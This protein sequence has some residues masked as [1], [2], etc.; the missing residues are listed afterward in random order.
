MISLQEQLS[1]LLSPGIT[2]DGL[3]IPGSFDTLPPRDN[4][5][6][7]SLRR[8]LSA[9][10][11]PQPEQW[12]RTG[13]NQFKLRTRPWTYSVQ[14]LATDGKHWFVSRA[15]SRLRSRILKFDINFRRISAQS[16]PISEGEHLGDIDYFQGLIYGPLERTSKVIVFDTNLNIVKIRKLNR[17]N[18]TPQ[19]NSFPWCAIHPWNGLLYSSKFDDATQILG[20]DPKREFALVHRI[21]LGKTIDRVQGGVISQQGHLFL[22]SDDLRGDAGIH[23]FSLLNG[24]YLGKRSID[25]DRDNKEEVEGITI[26]PIKIG[27][28][29]AQ[30]HMVLL[31]NIP[32]DLFIKSFDVPNTAAV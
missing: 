31:Q 8:I 9:M 11:S 17:G 25:I 4:L 5:G 30:I 23:V 6:R 28:K 20:Y 13:N 16:I 1:I 26:W 12:V 18:N 3:K 10:N 2:F 21:E 27:E 24:G 15:P 22:T 19:G 14:G 29:T 32:G 7:L